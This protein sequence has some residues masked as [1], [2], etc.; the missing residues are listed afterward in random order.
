[1]TNSNMNY[2]GIGK[3]CYYLIYS[4]DTKRKNY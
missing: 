3:Y 2:N 4:Y 1:M